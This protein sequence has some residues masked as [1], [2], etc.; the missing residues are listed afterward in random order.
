MI[1]FEIPSAGAS[2]RERKIRWGGGVNNEDISIP[3]ILVKQKEMLLFDKIEFLNQLIISSSH[4]IHICLK[5]SDGQ[6]RSMH[7][8]NSLRIQNPH[9]E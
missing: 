1:K 8:I 3:E 2:K 5:R 9:K 6:E 7:R 4:R